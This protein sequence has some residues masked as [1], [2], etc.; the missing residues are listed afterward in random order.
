MSK[1]CKDL[2]Q[3]NNKKKTGGKKQKNKKTKNEQRMGMDILPKKKYKWPTV[4]C[5]D[6]QHH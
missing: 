3:L 4:T 5:K 2:T 6:A 1:I